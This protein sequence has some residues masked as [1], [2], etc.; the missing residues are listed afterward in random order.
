MLWVAWF[1]GN[2]TS[3]FTLFGLHCS[4]ATL[5]ELYKLLY[6]VCNS[7]VTF[8]FVSWCHV[9]VHLNETYFSF[10]VLHVYKAV[11]V[12]GKVILIQ[13]KGQFFMSWKDSVLWYFN[14]TEC[15]LSLNGGCIMIC[16]FKSFCI[17]L[18]GRYLRFLQHYCWVIVPREVR[19]FTV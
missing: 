7:Y 3:F 13:V 5:Q 11:W 19:R 15:Y 4:V 9:S 12:G 1:C 17:L 6:V 10:L 2:S 18:L 8:Y 16:S 14:L